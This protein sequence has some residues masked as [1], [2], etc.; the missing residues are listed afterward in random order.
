MDRIFGYLW[1]LMSGLAV[2]WIISD[3]GR[4]FAE[5]KT[6]NQYQLLALQQTL[7][8]LQENE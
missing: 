1:I 3:I 4:N 5:I 8:L 6:Q 7:K 2:I